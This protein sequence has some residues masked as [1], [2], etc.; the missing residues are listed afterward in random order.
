MA[1]ML[2]RAI[3]NCKEEMETVE[4][5][6]DDEDEEYGYVHATNGAN[7]SGENQSFKEDLYVGK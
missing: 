7:S 5:G 1:D 2:S 4:F 3:F 6:E